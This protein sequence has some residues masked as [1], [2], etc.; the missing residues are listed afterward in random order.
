M[1]LKLS[2]LIHNFSSFQKYS[3]TRQIINENPLVIFPK[4]LIILETSKLPKLNTNKVKINLGNHNNTFNNNCMNFPKE[5]NV[6]ALFTNN[7]TLASF[8]SFLGVAILPNTCLIILSAVICLTILSLL[9]IFLAE[10]T[11]AIIGNDETVLI[12]KLQTFLKLLTDILGYINFL[13]VITNI[14]LT[15]KFIILFLNKL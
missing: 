5:I 4:K 13:N 10:F 1:F 8:V 9:N 15:A 7:S 11:N 14:F 3:K 12:N 6:K 2:P